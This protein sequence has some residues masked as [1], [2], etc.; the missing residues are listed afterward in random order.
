MNGLLLNMRVASIMKRT[1]Q[2]NQRA[3][4]CDCDC[5][6]VNTIP[7]FE[8]NAVLTRRPELGIDCRFGN[9][10]LC[11]GL[12]EVGLLDLATPVFP[13][14]LCERVSCAGSVDCSLQGAITGR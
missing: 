2:V 5:R 7:P 12:Q 14:R 1:T 4:I 11:H 9:M 6:D 10:R 13:E 8:E 3:G